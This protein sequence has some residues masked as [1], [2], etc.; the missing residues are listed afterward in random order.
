[1][2]QQQFDQLFFESRYAN[3]FE[4]EDSEISEDG[5]ACI[6]F[7]PNGQALTVYADGRCELWIDE[8]GD[9]W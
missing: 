1:M 5:N 6:Y 4:V 9:N 3:T 8:D 2:T 7:D